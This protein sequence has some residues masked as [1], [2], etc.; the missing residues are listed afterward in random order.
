M[1]AELARLDWPLAGPGQGSRLPSPPRPATIQ[2]GQLPTLPRTGVGHGGPGFGGRQR[3]PGL[4]QL[5]GDAV[6]RA[7]ESHAAVTRRA[8][9]RYAAGDEGAAS[10]VDVVHGVGE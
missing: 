3:T 5:D 7:D 9:D 6:R 8:V 10:V 4:Q 1:G 2:S